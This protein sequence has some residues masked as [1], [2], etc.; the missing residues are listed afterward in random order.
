MNE[1]FENSV[2][3]WREIDD[4][5]V[6]A[7]SLLDSIHFQIRNRDYRRGNPLGSSN[8]RFDP[9]EKLS[10]IKWLAEIIVGPRIQQTYDRLFAFLGRENENG[11]MQFLSTQVFK[12]MMTALA[13]KHEIQHDYVIDPLLR[14]V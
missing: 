12:N 8:K 13:R 11:S 9:R 3:R 6:A 4:L 1:V 14:E 2:F 5:T 10:Q 7:D